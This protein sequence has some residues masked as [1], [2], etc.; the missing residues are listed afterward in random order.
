VIAAMALIP[1]SGTIRIAIAQDTTCVALFDS[2]RKNLGVNT[3]TRALNCVDRADD[4]RRA[5]VF[6]RI[7]SEM[8]DLAQLPW[9]IPEYHDEQ[10]FAMPAGGYGPMAYIFASPYIGGFKYVWQIREQGRMGILAAVVFV[11]APSGTVLTGPYAK[12]HLKAG[13]NCIWLANNTG[14][15]AGNWEAFVTPASGTT[16]VCARPTPSVPPAP[17][18]APL[19]VTRETFSG[20]RQDDYPGAARFGEATSGQPLLGVRC[21]DGWCE[22]GPGD[23]PMPGLGGTKRERLVRGWHDSQRLSVRDAAGFHPGPRAYIVPEENLDQLSP[24]DFTSWRRVAV[25]TFVDDPAGTKYATWGLHRDQN[26]VDARFTSGKWEFQVSAGSRPPRAW[27]HVVPMSHLDAPVPGT[28]RWRWTLL[29]E[30][31]WIP[32]GNQCCHV[33]GQ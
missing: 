25:I 3:R 7:R 15:G 23:T 26:F 30:G 24:A 29:D 27:T 9:K 22:L 2:M 16:A 32:C 20:F 11:D 21:L 19:K 6:E 13:M 18:P 4:R 1:L 14:T 5:R 33:D 8:V 31:I 28:V 17:A 10:P 12:L